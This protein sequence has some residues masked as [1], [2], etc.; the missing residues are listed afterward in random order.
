MACGYSQV[1]GID[2]QDSYSPVMNDITHRIMII[3]AIIWDLTQCLLDIEVAFLHGDIED[4]EIYMNIPEG[5]NEGQDK[6][7]FLN[8]TI[9]GLVQSARQY[10]RK[11]VKILRRIGFQGGYADPCLFTKRSEKGILILGIYVDDLYC[12]GHKTAIEDFLKVMKKK[13]D[14]KL[15]C[16]WNVDDY[17]SN[18]LKMEKDGKSAVLLQPHIIK[19]LERMYG[20]RVEKL[21]KYLTPGTP[22]KGVLKLKEGMEVVDEITHSEYRT[23][24]GMLLYL[25]KA[26]RPDLSNAVRELSKVLD[27]PSKLAVKEM[28]RVIKFV[29]DTRYY[30]LKIEPKKPIDECW[31]IVCYSDSDYGGDQDTRRSVTGYIIY[32]LG[33]PICWRSKSQNVISLSSAEAELYA[34]SE[35]SKEI[36]FIA[37]V[38]LSLGI[39]V[40]MPITVRVDNVG[41][42]FMAENVNVS[43]RTKHIDIRA[44]FITQ[45]VEDGF[46]KI[47]FVRS[48]NNTADVFTKNTSSATYW[49]HAEEFV[50]NSRKE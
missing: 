37:Q 1:P 27:S 29:L 12:V 19:K 35:A 45:M 24:V 30:G 36:K 31:D 8:K 34:L 4:V 47:I 25:L 3:C 50:K 5:M 40:K 28:Y 13:S 23:G 41:A 32:L 6:C 14:F 46:I 22:N 17:L 9:Y 39:K 49:K 16:S 42:I 15:K 33:V 11:L 20:K 48:E 44:R 18:Q 21:Q 26:S 2:Y 38:L 10:N 43:Q 7:L